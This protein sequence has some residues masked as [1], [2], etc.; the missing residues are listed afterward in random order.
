MNV[1][2]GIKAFDGEDADMSRIFWRD[3]RVHQNITHAV[4]PDSI[5][6]MHCWHQKVRLEKAHPGDCYGDLLVDTEQSFQV[7]K[8]WLE[9]FRSALGAEGLR[10]PLWFKRPLKS[11]LEKFYL[12]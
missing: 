2:D 5:S 10:R 12:K 9:N 4:H 3:G 8:D 7:Y 1:L 11:V 6:G